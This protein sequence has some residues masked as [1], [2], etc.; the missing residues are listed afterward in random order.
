MDRADAARKAGFFL[1]GGAD[2]CLL[3][4]DESTEPGQLYALGKLLC[5]AGF[6]VAA[7]RIFCGAETLGSARASNWRAWIDEARG[8]CAALDK[9]YASVSVTGF[10]LGGTL[11]LILASRHPVCAVVAVSPAMGAANPLALWTPAA[12]P[13]CIRPRDRA[14]ISRIARRSLFAV[15]S[16]LLVVRSRL[17]GKILP[18]GAGVVLSGASSREKQMTVLTQF[19]PTIGEN[20]GDAA[21]ADAIKNHLRHALAANWLVN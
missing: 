20:P 2:A 5:E 8:A 14:A 10:S 15:V 1:E 9:R 12:A 17:D 3:L 7:P 16:P 21:L 18:D 6:S 4:H 11:A 13:P 19:C